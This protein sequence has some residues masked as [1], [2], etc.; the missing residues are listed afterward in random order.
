M[1]C[2][3]RMVDEPTSHHCLLPTDIRP[4]GRQNAHPHQ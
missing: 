2:L 3:S 4:A 1:T